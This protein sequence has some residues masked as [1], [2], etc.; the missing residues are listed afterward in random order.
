MKAKTIWI[1]VADGAHARVFERVGATAGLR[2]AANGAFEH[3]V[4]RTHEMGS[5]R[6]GRAVE[7]VGGARHAVEPR[8][9]WSEQEKQRFAARLAAHLEERAQREGFDRL[10]LVAPPRFLGALRAELGAHA[11][12]RLAGRLDKDLTEL[13]PGDIEGRLAEAAL[14]PSPTAA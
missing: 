6:P 11:R 4:E 2:L 3:K 14:I 9:D 12:A 8:V 10:V 13:A 7:S 5:E 1:L